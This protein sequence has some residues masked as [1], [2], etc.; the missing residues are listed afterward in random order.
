MTSTTHLNRFKKGFVVS[1]RDLGLI[2]HFSR[3]TESFSEKTCLP[4]FV[5][6]VQLP[7]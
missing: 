3:T 7:L 6:E 1:L 5:K 2:V 4:R